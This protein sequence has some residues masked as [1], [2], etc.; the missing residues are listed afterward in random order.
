MLIRKVLTFIYRAFWSALHGLDNLYDALRFRLLREAGTR[1]DLPVRIVP[2]RGFGRPDWFFLQGRVLVR[3]KIQRAPHLRAWDQLLDTYRRF[4][5]NEIPL[6]RLSIVL[7]SQTFE[8]FTDAEGYF[9][10]EQPLAPPLPR[11]DQVWLPVTIRLLETP[12]ASYQQTVKTKILIPPAG[13]H[14]GIITDVDDTILHTGVTSWLKW[15]VI[16]NTLF[17]SVGQRIA[18][19]QAGAFFQALQRG[20]QHSGYNPVFYVSNSPRNL[21]DFIWR[22]LRFNK[23]PK[24]PL[25]LKDIGLPFALHRPLLRSHKI[26]S[27]I[28]ILESYPDLPFI[29]VGDS[30]EK[31][32]F[33]YDEIARH[34]PG[35][36]KAVF[37]RDV[38]HRRRQR[39]IER[40]LHVQEPHL[41]ISFFHTYAEAA[42]QAQQAGL[43]S[44]PVFTEWSEKTYRHQAKKPS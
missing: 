28:R 43:L 34:F 30:G 19:H 23:F 41:A 2:Y 32:V 29:L 1:L 27:I 24:G 33:I 3:K 26:E 11:E 12:W 35:Q 8:V 44:L 40:F 22:F 20:P 16:Y 42:Q 15:K 13:A 5:S 38:Q 31:D 14:F 17:K 4:A 10:L 25:L 39:R 6:A 18:F 36:I 7:A 9:T 21:Y 37:I